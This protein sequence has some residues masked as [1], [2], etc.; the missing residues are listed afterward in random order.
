MFRTKKYTILFKNETSSPEKK[1]TSCFM[2]VMAARSS[3]ASNSAPKRAKSGV[4]H[5]L[6]LT[7]PSQVTKEGFLSRLDRAKQRLFRIGMVDNYRLL[8]SLL[9]SLEGRL[10]GAK[11]NSSDVM[12]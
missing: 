10:S 4:R 11:M 1:Y 12:E 7:F 5:R 2:L 3:T 8:T 9:D 6:Q